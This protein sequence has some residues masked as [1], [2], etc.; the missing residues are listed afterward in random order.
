MVGVVR[1]QIADPEFTA[2]AR[3]GHAAGIRTCLSCNQECAGRVGRNRWLGCTANPRAGRESVPLPPPATPATLARRKPGTETRPALPPAMSPRG[4]PG[5]GRRVYVV[6]GGP[7]GLQAAVTAAERGR[8]TL[9][10]GAAHTGGQADV[11]GRMPGRAGFGNLTDD[12]ADQARRAGVSVETSHPVHEEFLRAER[13][14]AVV[15]ATGAVPVQPDW[16]HGHPRVVDVRQVADGSARPEGTVVVVDELGFH[17]A[18]SIAE[19][20]ANRGCTV[21][22]IT[23]ALVVGQ[24]LGLTLDLEL[25]TRMAHAQ[26]VGQRTDV[27]VLDA[28]EDGTGR[29]EL[30]L[31]HHPTGDRQRLACD[32][33]ACAVPP[34][35]SDELWRALRGTGPDSAPFEV[36]RVGDCLAP[37]RAHAAV[38]EGERVGAAL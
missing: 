30:T 4:R 13:P 36:H 5:A 20:L 3:A 6:G 21:E 22:V 10:E 26:G 12:L 28:G 34:R 11:A 15:L 16:A 27:V 23:S 32:W 29:V 38:I 37:R 31:L 35:P 19:L 14:D 1:G 2:K 25:W 7:G 24:D 9:F 17:Q 8:V 33:V 18:T